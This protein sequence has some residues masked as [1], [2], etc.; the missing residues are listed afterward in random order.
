MEYLLPFIKLG[1]WVLT[2]H[3]DNAI[4]FYLSPISEYEMNSKKSKKDSSSK[5]I[6]I[7]IFSTFL[8]LIL[9]ESWC[10]SQ[11]EKPTPVTTEDVT[12]AFQVA[13][14]EID[15]LKDGLS[16]RAAL[17]PVATVSEY[18]QKVQNEMQKLEKYLNDDSL[19]VYFVKHSNLENRF[20]AFRGTAINDSNRGE[21]ENILNDFLRLNTQIYN[22]L[23]EE[24]LK[25]RRN[26]QSN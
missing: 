23:E 11:G 18:D 15:N 21:I 10:R 17:D 8:L 14:S 6:F 4:S 1:K 25:Y 5:Y 3:F 19:R 12:Y 22:Y 16:E 26:D 13:L 9:G 24:Y 20:S 7:A 2:S